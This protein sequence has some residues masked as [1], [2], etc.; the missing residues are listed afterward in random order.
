[1]SLLQVLLVCVL[2]IWNKIS[3]VQA[4]LEFDIIVTEADLELLICPHFLSSGMRNNEVSTYLNLGPQ[5]RGGW[6]SIWTCLH[7]VFLSYWVTPEEKGQSNWKSLS[8]LIIRK[9][10]TLS[11]TIEMSVEQVYKRVCTQLGLSFPQGW[12]QWQGMTKKRNLIKI[13]GKKSRAHPH[14]KM[15][16]STRKK[17]SQTQY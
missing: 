14:Y 1:M 8:W 15:P 10:N 3:V 9:G 12:H 4:G 5:R 11:I 6:H 17:G 13:W 16:L 7:G 2:F